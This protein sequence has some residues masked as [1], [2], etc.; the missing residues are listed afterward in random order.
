MSFSYN[1]GCGDS[2]TDRKEA[3]HAQA[4]HLVAPDLELPQQVG[5]AQLVR[6]LPCMQKAPGLIPSTTKENHDGSHLRYSE[7]PTKV[8]TPIPGR[9]TNVR[10]SYLPDAAQLL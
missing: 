2:L 8:A 10:V 7:G 3:P 6:C 9:A 1:L 4:S 5:M